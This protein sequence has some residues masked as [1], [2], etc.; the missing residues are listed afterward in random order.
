LTRDDKTKR[1]RRKVKTRASAAAL[2]PALGT[3]KASKP[4]VP[5]LFSRFGKR[6]KAKRK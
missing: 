3:L 6:R 1:A 5:R 2:P 4:I